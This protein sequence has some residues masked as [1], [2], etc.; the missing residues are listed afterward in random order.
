LNFVCPQDPLKSEWVAVALGAA[1]KATGRPPNLGA[2]GAPG[3]FALADGDRLAG[4]LTGA[5]LRDVTL[6]PLVRPVRLGRTVDDATGY[7]LSLPQ[8]QELFAGAP[9]ETVAA[10]GSALRAAFA[11]YAGTHGVVLDSTAWLVS[12]HR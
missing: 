6:E 9:E 5:G 4:L 1:I 2:T 7:I 11:P 10:A 12:A 3:P 8:S